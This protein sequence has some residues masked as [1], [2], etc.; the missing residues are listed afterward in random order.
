M[1]NFSNLEIIIV[2]SSLGQPKF[3]SKNKSRLAQLIKHLNP[4]LKDKI[5]WRN[6]RWWEKEQI[7][8]KKKKI[9]SSSNVASAQNIHKKYC[10]LLDEKT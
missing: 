6:M 3:S 4:K 8:E 5:S 2:I 7:C 9:I 10:A 1:R